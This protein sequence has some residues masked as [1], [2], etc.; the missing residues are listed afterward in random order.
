MPLLSFPLLLSLISQR[1]SDRAE[2]FLSLSLFCAHTSFLLVWARDRV[3]HPQR[4]T[5][6]V[7]GFVAWLVYIFI[8]CGA[9]LLPFAVM[10][11]LFLLPY[12]PERR[13]CSTTRR[14]GRG[15]RAACSVSSCTRSS[16]RSSKVVPVRSHTWHLR[17]DAT[18]ACPR[19]FQGCRRSCS[20]IRRSALGP[21]A[22]CSPRRPTGGGSRLLPPSP[23]QWRRLSW[24]CAPRAQR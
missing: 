22:A 16:R 19:R 1:I 18:K 24:R 14:S 11:R 6:R 8:Q 3:K 4:S 5:Y 9:F 13:N 20:T 7:S 12:A 10:R 23:R 15:P 2:F 21:R 17:P